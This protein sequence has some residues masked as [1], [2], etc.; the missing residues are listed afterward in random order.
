MSLI[1]YLDDKNSFRNL[2]IKNGITED[3]LELLTILK[4]KPVRASKRTT[5]R[6]SL[7]IGARTLGLHIQKLRDYGYLVPQ[8][9]SDR[10]TLKGQRVYDKAQKLFSQK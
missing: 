2:A 1:N 3:N 4:L 10:L 9:G 5:L 8:S 7:G 6:A